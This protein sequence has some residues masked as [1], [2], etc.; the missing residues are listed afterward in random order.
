[1]PP[2]L[3]RQS[4]P[5]QPVEEVPPFVLRALIHGADSSAIVPPDTTH[6]RPAQN[7]SQLRTDSAER[8]TQ[9]L[10]SGAAVS[11]KC[12]FHDSVCHKTLRLTFV[13]A[14]MHWRAGRCV[15]LCCHATQ[16][17]PGSSH[18]RPARYCD[19]SAGQLLPPSPC[20]FAGV[21]DDPPP[22][23]CSTYQPARAPWCTAI[24]SAPRHHPLRA[25][26]TPEAGSPPS[27]PY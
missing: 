18:S 5:A 27:M 16:R 19:S 20:N 10:R 12:G 21:Q 2:V 6:P 1:M 22:Q 7:A 15:L 11:T 13:G 26:S 3:W 9:T 14:T 23:T 17:A 8:H 24:N 4:N 25:W